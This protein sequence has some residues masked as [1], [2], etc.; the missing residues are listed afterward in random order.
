MQDADML[1]KLSRAMRIF[2]HG[3]NLLL[4]DSEVIN[5]WE[6]LQQAGSLTTEVIKHLHPEA[7]HWGSPLLQAEEEKKKAE[8][9]ASMMQPDANPD[10]N[11]E[12]WEDDEEWTDQ[13]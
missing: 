7:E 1:G 3:M 11:D 12:E 5:P 4:E 13:E 9:V 6:F 2:G 10:T 8:V